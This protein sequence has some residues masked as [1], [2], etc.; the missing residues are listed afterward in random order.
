MLFS[1]K[2][3]QVHHKNR[4]YCLKTK[5]YW[6]TKQRKQI[7]ARWLTSLYL[8]YFNRDFLQQFSTEIPDSIF[9]HVC[10]SSRV[11]LVEM[12]TLWVSSIKG[13][14]F[15]LLTSYFIDVSYMDFTQNQVQS[16][17]NN[18]PKKGK[19]LK[20]SCFS[21]IS[22]L[23]CS[24]QLCKYN[25]TTQKKKFSAAVWSQYFSVFRTPSVCFLFFSISKPL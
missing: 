11:S 14:R 22:Y 9:S 10:T 21:V 8:S 24:R 5:F 4:R 12:V 3:K 18:L 7:K 17:R 13:H 20:Q 16:Y 19:I 15:F 23:F 25:L 6:H 1:I 2:E